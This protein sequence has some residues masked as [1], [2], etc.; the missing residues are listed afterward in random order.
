MYLYI[1]SSLAIIFI[2]IAH[3]RDYWK[4]KTEINLRLTR[5]IV[6]IL[7]L[8]GLSTLSIQLHEV[9]ASSGSE[10]EVGSLTLLEIDK[11]NF[12]D[13]TFAGRWNLA[14]KDNGK[15]L[16][17]LSIY[18][19]PLSLLL[20]RGSIKNK[21]SLFLIYTQG[22]IL[23]E[24]ITGITKGLIDRYRPFVYRSITEINSLSIESKE[25][26]LEDIADADISNSFFS[27]D[28]SVT[29]FGFI[30]FAL[31]YTY[32]YDD[33]KY[34]K[35]VSILAIIGTV[36]VCYFRAMSGKHF[37]TDVAIGA[38]VG[39]LIALLIVKVHKKGNQ[40]S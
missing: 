13:R 31:S 34:K 3:Q 28:T 2:L 6:I 26:F 12:I 38:I 20:F 9:N 1:L 32:F 19:I 11:I 29:A 16:K 5:E 8:V 39:S 40:L 35:L 18:I 33:S 37:P 17:N 23:T 22:Y 21:L 25:E 4:E 14:A 27:G 7:L 24:S 36:L 30:F 10:F 15:Y